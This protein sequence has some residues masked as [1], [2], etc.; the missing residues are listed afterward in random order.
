MGPGGRG[1]QD[2]RWMMSCNVRTQQLMGMQMQKSPST[3]E[4]PGLRVVPFGCAY[5]T[6]VCVFCDDC[7][8]R[9]RQLVVVP[10]SSRPLGSRRS[11]KQALVSLSLSLSL[12]LH[13]DN[14]R[15]PY[16][17]RQMAG[18]PTGHRA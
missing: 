7:T 16:E 10:R 9:Q 5:F 3:W 8:R 1:L 4:I 15:E 17:S 14:E 11:P 18:R 2:L 12:C 13:Q 6:R